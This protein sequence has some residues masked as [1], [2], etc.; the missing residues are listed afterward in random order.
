L[1]LPFPK[2][3]WKEVLMQFLPKKM[4]EINLRAFEEGRRIGKELFQSQN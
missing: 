4:L 3:K 1:R 2:E